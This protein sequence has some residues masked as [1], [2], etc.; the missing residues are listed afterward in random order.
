MSIEITLDNMKI[1]GNAK[2]LNNANLK[3]GDTVIRLTNLALD[4]NV[5]VL[6]DLN[7]D[8]FC[9]TIQGKM[10]SMDKSSEEYRQI[11]KLLNADRKNK[12][13][14]S[15]KLLQHVA[16]FAEGVAVNILSSMIMG[17]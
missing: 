11:E 14:F 13:E 7:I 15:K 16:S 17:C 4:S 10:Q 6:Q 3:N 12:P 1:S 9:S 5:E 8:S 2:V